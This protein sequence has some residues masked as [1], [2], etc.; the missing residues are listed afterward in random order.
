M[1][2]ELRLQDAEKLL[3]KASV[4]ATMI[5]DTTDIN[6]RDE[7]AKQALIYTKIAEAYIKLAEQCSQ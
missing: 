2:K 1:N 5:F 7:Y 3:I 6:L 4:S